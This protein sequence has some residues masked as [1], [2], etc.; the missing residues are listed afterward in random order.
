MATKF[1]CDPQCA[2]LAVKL[3]V[4]RN[5]ESLHIQLP[6]QKFDNEG[7]DNDYSNFGDKL[8]SMEKTVIDMSEDI[9]FDEDSNR[10]KSLHEFNG[11]LVGVLFQEIQLP[12]C[13]GFGR[14]H[15]LDG[16]LNVNGICLNSGCECSVSIVTENKRKTI[17]VYVSNYDKKVAHSKSR[18][19]TDIN[20]RTKLKQLLKWESAMVVHARLAEEYISS[21]KI[22]PA[23][24]PSKEALRKIKTRVKYEDSDI[25]DKN[26][27]MSILK[28]KH[29]ARYDHTIHKVGAD[30]F[31]VIF[32][33]PLQG[34]FVKHETKHD[35]GV[36]SIDATGIPIQAPEYS[37]MS[38]ISGTYKRSYFYLISFQGSKNVPIFQALSQNHTHEFIADMLLFWKNKQLKGKFPKEI[39]VDNSAA[40]LLACV[41]VVTNSK[42]LNEYLSHCF[43]CLFLNRQAPLCYIRLDRA[44]FVHSI[45]RNKKLNKEDKMK[46]KF[47]QQILGYLIT[48]ESI[49]IVEQTCHDLFVVMKNN[50]L[51]DSYVVEARNRLLRIANDHKHI[52]DVRMEGNSDE[53]GS[54]ISEI[55]HEDVTND[56]NVSKFAAWVDTVAKKVDEKYVN[57]KMNENGPDASELTLHEANYY[58]SEKLQNEIIRILSKLPLFSNIMNRTF[59]SSNL[60]ASTACTEVRFNHVK[61]YIFPNM[62]KIRP[63]V[64]IMKS[65]HQIK[66]QFLSIIAKNA[67]DGANPE[68]ESREKK[69]RSIENP[70]KLENWRGY[71]TEDKKRKVKRSKN[72]ILE[73]LSN[74]TRTIPLLIN[75]GVSKAKGRRM[76]T[77]T[78]NTCGFDSIYHI[79]AAAYV[80]S[81]TFAAI[82]DAEEGS[83]FANFIKMSFEGTSNEIIRQRNEVLMQLMFQEVKEVGS[84]LFIDCWCGIHD[85]Y[86]KIQ[87]ECS[88]ITS[89]TRKSTCSKCGYK[90]TRSGAFMR[91]LLDRFTIQNFDAALRYQNDR[92]CSQCNS[93]RIDEYESGPLIA[94]DVGGSEYNLDDIAKHV[95]FGTSK[96]ILHAVIKH[97]PGHFVSNIFRNNSWEEFD[98]KKSKVGKANTKGVSCQIIFYIKN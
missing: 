74:R 44:H 28:M 93:Q 62:T 6:G 22:Y 7:N 64:W 40:L 34:E 15:T 71:A 79:V 48:C 14:L 38:E 47:Y 35:G 97:L 54:N 66:G 4:K 84:T 33:D 37:A 52:L 89:Q 75:G 57:H 67:T 19:T 21:D 56:R 78:I 85:L 82:M 36:F 96:Y 60:T 53:N 46:C 11:G 94:F 65:I 51:C 26:I 86:E 10:M 98:D 76:S 58:A 68:D 39:I 17:I 91:L 42:S 23:H 2:Y 25:R 77:K 55:I 81:P 72:T 13:W 87:T 70:V 29:D 32:S 5:N 30:P 90:S 1:N 61:N 18:Y 59:G 45:I 41:L 95:E 12:C 92:H 20:D 9:F 80:Y 88:S 3:Y 24:L 73:P 83:I 8:S 16:E 49:D 43:D 69:I 27:L 63:D 31:F 50:F